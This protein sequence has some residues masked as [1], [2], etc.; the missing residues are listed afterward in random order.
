MKNDT[1]SDRHN[2]LTG[3]YKSVIYANGIPKSSY[4]LSSVPDYNLENGRQLNFASYYHPERNIGSYDIDT[5]P[6]YGRTVAVK[7]VDDNKPNSWES[8]AWVGWSYPLN[9]SN[10]TVYGQEL[11]EQLNVSYDGN[12]L[13]E[14]QANGELTLNINWLF[15]SKYGYANV[16]PAYYYMCSN[17]NTFPS[18]DYNV[19][20]DYEV[21]LYFNNLRNTLPEYA[22][23]LTFAVKPHFQF[24]YVKH[25]GSSNNKPTTHGD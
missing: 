22:N 18:T 20:L 16:E 6:L 11:G 5:N 8:A 4:I 15:G 24:Q 19:N 3:Q 23:K 10:F 7:V 9:T 12:D 17:S 13:S 25:G 1:G 14:I 2:R 21:T